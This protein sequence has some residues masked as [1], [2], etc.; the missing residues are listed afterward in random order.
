MSIIRKAYRIFR[1]NLLHKLISPSQKNIFES[2]KT[3][4]EIIG[5]FGSATGIGESARLCANQLT[6]HG[7]KVK[8][9]SIESVFNKKAEIDWAF[10]D[11]ADV[12]DVGC[13]II[14]LNPTML[15]PYVFS[16]GLSNFRK[17]YNIGYWA[18]ELE[19][20][21]KEWQDASN[22]M[23]AIFSPSTFTA[24]SIKR[25]VHIPV[26]TVPHPVSTPN[27]TKGIKEKL[28]IPENT[29]VISSIFSFGSSMDRKNPIAII[30][31]FT[32]S[33]AE[34]SSVILIL[35]ASHGHN[36]KEKKL[37]KE[38]I[39]EHKNIMLIDELWPFS[40]VAGLI[41]ES[42]VYISLHRSEGFGLTIAEA[43]LLGTA[44]ITT[45]WSGNMDFC[46][47]D[48]C[49]L[50]ESEL[51]NI[52]TDNPDLANTK[53]VKWAEVNPTHA[54]SQLKNAIY[55]A[56]LNACKVNECKNKTNTFF[57]QPYYINALEEF[58][59]SSQGKT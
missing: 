24:K 38:M 28:S 5:F 53:G 32:E 46:N 26:K 50:V 19:Q 10:D 55:D 2:R 9:T 43:M 13:R 59:K 25:S 56:K 49:F 15:P 58:T 14:H 22:Y 41:K 52:E 57:T 39:E 18:W 37:I 35:K 45:N 7:Y 40:D 12:E 29:K 16:L 34:D 48:N 27:Y 21:P 36:T 31:A 54:T 33:F 8:C 4:I 6:E 11:T 23:N 51:V 20:I 17:I 42:D 30:K 3:G 44:T 1:K 47:K